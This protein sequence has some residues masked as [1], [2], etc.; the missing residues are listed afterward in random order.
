VSRKVLRGRKVVGGFAEGPAL[1]ADTR[2]SFWGGFD[3]VAGR[4]VEVGSPLEGQEVTGKVLVFRSTKGS[5]GTSRMLRLAK[6]TGRFPAAFINTDL[7]ELSV[8]ACVAQ[9]LPLVTDL[10]ENPFAA[11]KTGDWVRVDADR[12]IIEVEVS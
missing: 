3:P 11:I 1:V 12:G 2:L 8:L 4:I 6:I 9:K 10:D 5:S 7:D